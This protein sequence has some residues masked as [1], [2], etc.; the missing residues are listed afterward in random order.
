MSEQG[1]PRIPGRC[2][3]ETGVEPQRPPNAPQQPALRYRLGTHAAFLRRMI[4]RLPRPAPVAGAPRLSALTTRAADDPSIA[5]LDACAAVA[6]VL[7]FYQERIA[8]EGFLR[9]ATERRSVLELAR[10]VGYEL[11][12]GV[13]ASAWLAFEVESAAG[14]PESVEVPKGTRVQSVPG[15]GQKPQTFETSEPLLARPEW[16]AMPARATQTWHPGASETELPLQGLNTGLQA[17]DGILLVEPGGAEWAFRILSMVVT[18]PADDLTLV[19]WRRPLN[20]ESRRSPRVFALRE[21]MPVFGHNAAAEQERALDRHPAVVDAESGE[22][23]KRL[24]LDGSWPRVVPGS[25]IVVSATRSR[26]RRDSRRSE[27]GLLLEA[28][29]L[30]HV[31]FLSRAAFGLSGKITRLRFRSAAD[32]SDFEIRLTTVFTR[33]EE[34]AVAM[35]PASNMV[36]GAAITLAA[37][38]SGLHAG[39]HLIISGAPAGRGRGSIESEHAVLARVE[40]GGRVL[41]LERALQRAYLPATTVVQANVVRATHG[42]SVTEVLGSGDAAQANQSFVLRRAPL[43]FVEDPASAR[44]SSSTLELRVDGVRWGEKTSLYGLEAGSESYALRNEDGGRT[45][46]HFGDGRNGARVPSGVENV[47]VAYRV[48]I[49]PEGEVPAGRLTLLQTRPPGIRGVRNPMA[50]SGAGA[51][52]VLDRARANAPRSVLTLDRVVSLRDYEAFARGFAGIGK[53]RATAH[54]NGERRVVQITAALENG[55][56]IDA[57]KKRALLESLRRH[58]DPDQ[59][60]QVAGFTPRKFR[61]HARVG[62]DPRFLPDPVF[63]GVRARLREAFGFER[64]D[65]GQPVSAGEVLSVMQSEPGVLFVDLESLSAG[66]PPASSELLLLAA[67]EDAVRL[68]VAAV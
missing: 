51:P 32:F 62:V 53:A 67:A 42:E 64:R 45:T 65:F 39:Q 11:N 27:R 15:P 24:D 48:G 37:P 40:S 58:R 6:D 30:E 33:S 22:G 12:P 61:L 14:A 9:T 17:G 35:A 41:R 47:R 57:D 5:L 52:E 31:A 50:A 29:E 1:D 44:G 63:A 21:R 59:Q 66:D 49:G 16:N 7:C 36:S 10:S 18:R 28:A 54:W 3:S 68:E 2:C 38:G 4:E 26:A 43:T 19:G 20:W 23:M 13:A 25:W 8:N 46:V 34:L 55:Q 56:P 60:V